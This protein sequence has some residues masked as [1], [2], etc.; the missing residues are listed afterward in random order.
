MSQ[1]PV[2]DHA[3]VLERPARGQ[4]ELQENQEATG[5]QLL[6]AGVTATQGGCELDTEQRTAAKV[7]GLDKL[8]H[9]FHVV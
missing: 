6:R 1:V 4:A 8:G 9:L 7:T 5:Q 3:Q 2:R